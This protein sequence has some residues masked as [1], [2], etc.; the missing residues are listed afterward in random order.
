MNPGSGNQ[1]ADLDPVPRSISD[2]KS[3][4]YRR[5]GVSLTKINRMPKDMTCVI[6]MAP[7]EEKIPNS[8][9]RV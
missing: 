3:P 5:R 2:R 4:H 7:G 6:Q 1:N 8:K 9:E